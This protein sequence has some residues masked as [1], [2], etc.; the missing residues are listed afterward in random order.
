MILRAR[1]SGGRRAKRRAGN[2]AQDDD[3]CEIDRPEPGRSKSGAN[4][5]GAAKRD[6]ADFPIVP[7]LVV[8]DDPKPRKL[9]S[10]GEARAYVED[11]M[12]LGRPPAWRDIYARLKHVESAE[13]AEETIGALREL[14][15]LEELLIPPNLPLQP[16]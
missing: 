2:I 11:E 13:D 1:S 5:L 15:E 12:R 3:S 6:A 8:K 9:A 7:P 4:E 14:L 10:L 16:E